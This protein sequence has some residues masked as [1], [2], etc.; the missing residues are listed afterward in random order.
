MQKTAGSDKI[1]PNIV[2]LPANIIDSHLT[3]I[4]NSDLLQDSFSEDAKTASVR[5]L[6]KIK[7]RDK[8]ENYRLVSI[9]NCFSKIYEKFLLEA[10]KPFID[11]FL[12]EYIAAYREYYSWNEV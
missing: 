7:E 5:P 4:V 11:T 9:L 2:M 12:S 3:N 8:I 1:P 10:F 6:F